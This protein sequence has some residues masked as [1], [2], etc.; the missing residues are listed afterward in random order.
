MRKYVLYYSILENG[1]LCRTGGP[2]STHIYI[3]VSI[4][5]VPHHEVRGAVP[6]SRV[7]IAVWLGRLGRTRT[8]PMV[9]DAYKL[10]AAALHAS[11][12]FFMLCRFV[13]TIYVHFRSGVWPHECAIFEGGAV[14]RL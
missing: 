3:R 11:L 2:F 12:L 4:I 14:L 8:A 6:P 10:S 9:A 1:V 7:G 5:I 13:W